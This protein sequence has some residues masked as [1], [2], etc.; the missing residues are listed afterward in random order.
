MNAELTVPWT[1]ELKLAEL[2]AA[3]LCHDLASP[4]AA[5]DNGIELLNEP[6]F[7]ESAQALDLVSSSTSQ[8]V[9]TLRF[10]RSALG[11][12]GEITGR[13]SQVRE[14]GT[15]W[16]RLRRIAL[17]WGLE[18][19][20]LPPEVGRLLLNLLAIA[21]E[22]LPRGGIVTLGSTRTPAV[23]CYTAVASGPD[24]QLSSE[25]ARALEACS[26]EG[27]DPREVHAYFLRRLVQRSGGALDVEN[28]PEE[29]VLELVLRS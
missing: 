18:S 1:A 21:A 11:E 26:P 12:R 6:G 22:T 16:L 20:S 25:M 7:R 28:R 13:A 4:L 29:V 19:P 15:D 2:L 17:E 10:F 9:A 27:L 3:R 8:A 14:L 23:L 24:A 5:I